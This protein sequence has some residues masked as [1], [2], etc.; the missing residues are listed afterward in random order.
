[1]I[2]HAPARIFCAA[3]VLIAMCAGTANAQPKPEAPKPTVAALAAAR[4]ILELK[5]GLKLYDPIVGNVIERHKLLLLR[6]NPMIAKDLD[7]A[8]AKLHG[9]LESRRL[10]LQNELVSLYAQAFTEKELKETLAF[11]KSPLGKKLIEEEPKILDSSMK[12]ANNWTENLVKEVVQK[13][14]AEM[15]RRG[16]DM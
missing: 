3:A 12:W 16:H 14:R 13:L 8:A 7:A 2:F 10:E 5:G 4:Q 9:E 11:Y 6:A 15:K 1:M